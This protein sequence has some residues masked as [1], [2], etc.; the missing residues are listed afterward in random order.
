MNNFQ[1]NLLPDLK[2]NKNIT[3]RRIVITPKNVKQLLKL[4]DIQTFYNTLLKDGKY[5]AR[6][7]SIKVED[8]FGI[9]I[10]VKSNR[11][12]NIS[13][14]DD[15]ASNRVANPSKFDVA[16]KIVFFVNI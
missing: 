16:T 13:F 6:D 9:N 1:M 2:F 4:K 8:A 7:I 10:T 11:D 12:D 5:K 14:H 3:T 15:Y